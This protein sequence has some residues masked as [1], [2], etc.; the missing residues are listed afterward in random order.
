MEGKELQRFLHD[1]KWSVYEWIGAV[2]IDEL[3]QNAELA[4]RYERLERE[5]RKA[6]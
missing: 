2:S 3:S 1:L 6:A 5:I 4:L